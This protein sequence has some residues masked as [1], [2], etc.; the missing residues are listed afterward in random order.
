MFFANFLHYVLAFEFNLIVITVLSMLCQ[1]LYNNRFLKSITLHFSFPFPELKIYTDFFV[2]LMQTNHFLTLFFFKN[3][4]FSF[5]ATFDIK[6]TL[7]FQQTYLSSLISISES[8][9][10]QITHWFWCVFYLK[11]RWLSDIYCQWKQ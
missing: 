8:W 5:F 7:T 10:A 2:K 9:F 11:P 3:F 4:F 1:M 6:M